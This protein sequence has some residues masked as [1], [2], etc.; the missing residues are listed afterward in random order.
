DDFFELGGHS[1]LATQVLSRVRSLFRVDLQLRDVFNAPTV[2]KL[3]VLIDQALQ[4]GAGTQAPAIV[5]LPREGQLPLS[6]AQQRL[7]FLHQ[8]DASSP[9]YNV[10]MVLRL[11]GSLDVMALEQSFTELVRR[12]ESLRTSFHVVNGQATQV[13]HLAVSLPLAVINLSDIPE[14][15]RHEEVR[16][17][18]D[19]EAVHPFQLATGPL[20]RVKLL[21]LDEEEHILLLVMHHI[22]SDGWSMGVL[23][24]EMAA[25]YESFANGRTPVLPELPVQYADY[26]GWQRGWLQG[27][28]LEKQL[29]YWKRQLTG[30][31]SALELPTDRP[32]PAVQT[33]NGGSVPVKLGRELTEALKTLALKE[34]TTPFMVLLAAWQTLLSRYSGQDDI[35]VGTPIAGRQR[36]ETEGLIGF[37]VNTLVLRTT[38]DGDPT[39]RELLGR[40]R[41][42][43]LGAYAHQEVPFEKLVEALAP[44]RDTSRT[45]LFQV[46]MTLQNAPEAALPLTDLT[47]EGVEVEHRTAKFDL[48]LGL[49]E[50]ANGLEGGLEFNTD[51][52]DASTAER[53]ARHLGVLLEGIAANPDARLHQLPLLTPEDRAQVV[54]GWNTHERFPVDACLHSIFEAQVARTPGAVAVT[55]GEQRLTYRELD[56][57]ANQLA[58]H[59]RSLGVGP[60]VL[61]GLAVE[62]SLELMVGLLAILKAGGAYLPMD[63]AYPRERLEFMV[64]DARVPVVLTQQH[65]L[66]VVPSGAAKRLCLDSDAA[67]WA[68][69]PTTP[70]DSGVAPHHLAYVIYTSG[71][72][73]RP[74]GAQIE[75]AQVVRLFDG[76]KHWFDFGAKDVWTL[77]HSYAFDFSVWEMWGALLYGGR[78]VVV[79]YEVSRAPADFHALL[80][81]EGVTVLNQTPSAFRQLIQH[82]ERAGDPEGLSLRTV[83]FGGEALEFG[84]LRPWYARHADDAPVLVNM[85]G[86]TETTVH[87]TYRALKAADAEGGRGSEVGQPIPDLQ[88]YVLDAHGQPVPPGVT[89][90]LYVGGDGLGRGYLGR[91][92]LTAQRFIPDPFSRRPGARLYRSGD[93]A[94]WRPNGTLEYLGRADFQVKV[95]GF[96]IEL[97]EIEAGLLSHPSVREAVALVREDVPGDKRLVAYL[98]GAPGQAVAGAQELREQLRRTLPEYMVPAAFVTLDA[99]PLTSNGKV[100]RRALPAPDT[101][102]TEASTRVVARTPL[103]L[104]LVRIWEETLGVSPIGIRD[105]FFDLGGH[106]MLAVQLMGR[107]QQATGRNLPLASLF[108]ASTVEQL[109]ALLEQ[110]ARAWSPLVAL[111]PEGTRPPLFC[112]HPAGGGVLCYVD[113]ARELDADQPCYGLQA[114]GT[115]G[116]EPLGTVAEMAALYLASVRQV[117]PH[118]PYHLA[119]WSL[120]GIIAFEMARQLRAEGEEVALLASIDAYTVQHMVPDKQPEQVLEEMLTSELTFMLAT[121]TGGDPM[122]LR[123]RISRMTQAERVNY[124]YEVGSQSDSQIAE[125]GVDRVRNLYRVFEFTSRAFTSYDAK[126]LDGKLVLLRASQRPDTRED[127]G[128][129]G[130]VSGGVEVVDM[131]GSHM[132]MMRKPLIANV[133]K[134]LQA[135]IGS[136]TAP[137]DDPKKKLG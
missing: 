131:P 91:P 100:D 33:S 29:G 127:H 79:P 97:G 22:V 94:R 38:L 84:S 112:V 13:I 63:P 132:T 108:Q 4:A 78:L 137:V 1:L 32:R 76:T 28:V 57:R 51:L 56:R 104:Q 27:E 118:G 110:E 88:V 107:I 50:T 115:E 134:E 82:E 136:W 125:V 96:R 90:E 126:P 106:S 40:V 54:A 93:L 34:G 10:P 72:T 121:T 123:E 102:R 26:A 45:P 73:G 133:A 47:L 59:L 85:Y 6:F 43:T 92:E 5:P 105:D 98:V 75:H 114:R 52:F 46:S 128:W 30:A 11:K 15:E 39:F 129:E 2:E 49:G 130:L 55:Y 12:H 61:V 122:E 42:T 135:R 116:E 8:L 62:R 23:V 60:E 58:H 16:R 74:K 3:S 64:E 36:A 24:R 67:Q 80:K 83:V 21:K 120:G 71:S 31:P 25:F 20:L 113:L 48:A 65:L 53:I 99:L 66:D 81:R 41:E 44:T 101:T 7:W 37:F 17:L 95:R 35:S 124:F 77:F 18:A 119:G 14:P 86:I 109:A 68:S 9:A 19:E 111:K 87:V 69:A 89:G 70:P 117:Q 103:Q